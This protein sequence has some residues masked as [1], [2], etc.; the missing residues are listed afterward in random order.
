LTAL[1]KAKAESAV[2]VVERWIVA[3]LRNRK[4]FSLADLNQAIRELLVRLNERPF[5]KRDGSRASVFHSLEK[6]ALAPLPAE[7]FDMSQW[8]RA[9]VNID[10]HVAFDGNFY[11]VPYTLVQ[12]V[13]EVRSTPTTVEIFHKGNRIA[14]H[15]R[16]RRRG[17]TI[18]QGEHPSQQSSSPSGVAAFADGE[19]GAQ[20]RS[21]HGAVVRTNPARQAA[22][23]NGLPLL[24]GHH[25]LGAAVLCATHGS[26]G[27]TGA[28]GQG[29]SLS[30]REV[31][32]EE[33]AGYGSFISTTTRLPT[34]DP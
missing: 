26:R 32:L 21:Q 2:Q 23:G 5:R 27:G 11:S 29:L 6:P 9:T 16:S 14:S 28:A 4:F 12:Q 7:R 22:P 25:S 3:A 18:T 1:G 33:L 20:H 13:V 30:E 17:Q 31:D 19:L 8:S 10:Y 24:S 34:S 15:L